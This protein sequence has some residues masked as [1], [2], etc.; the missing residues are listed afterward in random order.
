VVAVANENI[1]FQQSTM[2]IRKVVVVGQT[3]LQMFVPV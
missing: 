1:P 2:H 3:Y